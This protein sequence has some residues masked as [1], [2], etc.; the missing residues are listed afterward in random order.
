MTDSI[1]KSP[2]A[3]ALERFIL[4]HLNPI[5]IRI[6][7]ERHV[8]HATVSQALLPVDIHRLEARARRVEVIDRNTCAVR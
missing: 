4:N 8:L 1:C 6:Q 2:V 7:N 3:G 5:A